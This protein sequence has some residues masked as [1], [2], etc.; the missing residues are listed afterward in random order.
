MEQIDK[1]IQDVAEEK[2]PINQDAD[3]W[4][5]P[6]DVLK[7]ERTAYESGANFMVGHIEK[8]IEWWHRD[9]RLY[10]GYGFM[11]K[12]DGHK[13]FMEVEYKTTSELISEYFST[14]KQD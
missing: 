11:L 3:G 14:L 1:I 4:H 6:S 2:Y 13:S 10:P 9:Y 5:M 12:S 7:N 8:F